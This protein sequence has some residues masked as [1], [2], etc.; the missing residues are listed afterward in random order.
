MINMSD[1]EAQVNPHHDLPV[2]PANMNLKDDFSLAFNIAYNSFFSKHPSECLAYGLCHDPD[3]PCN[4]RRLLPQI[5][6]I[7]ESL[8]QY[9]ALDNRRIPDKEV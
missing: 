2:Q 6:E 8:T 9:N 5:K 3:F 7:K 1:M 4:I